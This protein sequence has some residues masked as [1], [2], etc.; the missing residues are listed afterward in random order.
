MLEAQITTKYDKS[1]VNYGD[2]V[3]ETLLFICNK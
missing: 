1:V 3:I 2:K